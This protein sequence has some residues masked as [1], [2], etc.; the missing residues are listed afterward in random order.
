MNH[1][2][3][4]LALGV[5]LLLP[6]LAHAQGEGLPSASMHSLNGNMVRLGILRDGQVVNPAGV[7]AIT[8]TIVIRDAAGNPL[9]GWTVTMDFSNC[10]GPAADQEFMLAPEQPHHPGALTDCAGKRISAISGDDGVAT[11]RIVGGVSR[12]PGNPVGYGL[13]PV[14]ANA[15]VRVTINTTGQGESLGRLVASAADQDLS[16][17]IT[18]ADLALVAGDRLSV[19][20]NGNAVG[21]RAR[22][23]F[24]ADGTISAADLGIAGAI[25]LD[26]V[27]LGATS[28]ASPGCP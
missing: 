18:A 5:V 4:L 20:N 28:S 13:L 9:R 19:I 1:R 6:A 15:C 14:P 26:S 25:R 7:G 11:F 3:V 16:G 10:S 2:P 12:P 21:Y 24:N 23:D 17:G 8:K 27:Y 22:S